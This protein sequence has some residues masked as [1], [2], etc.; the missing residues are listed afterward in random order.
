MIE[1]W[2]WFP[3]YALRIQS[4][5]YILMSGQKA[6]GSSHFLPGRK[7]E[8]ELCEPA[9]SR[10]DEGG[11]WCQCILIPPLQTNDCKRKGFRLEIQAISTY[12]GIRHGI[13]IIPKNG[14]KNSKWKWWDSQRDQGMVLLK[15]QNSWIIHLPLENVSIVI[16][17]TRA[18]HTKVINGALYWE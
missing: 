3:S 15:F 14:E 6:T 8:A 18:L 2:Q 11:G 5:A 1:T 13:F 7:T 16:K 4:L 17:F 9:G 12:G 10:K